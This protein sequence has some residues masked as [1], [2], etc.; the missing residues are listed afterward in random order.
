MDLPGGQPGFQGRV[1]G[2]DDRVVWREPGAAHRLADAKPLAGGA[3]PASGVLGEGPTDPYGG[4]PS[5]YP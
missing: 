1:P 5:Q 2:I 4:A 3:E